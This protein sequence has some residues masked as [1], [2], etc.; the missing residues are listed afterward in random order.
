V[1]THWTTG[2]KDFYAL[3]QS[4]SFIVDDHAGTCLG[5]SEAGLIHYMVA[6]GR[7]E[8][9]RPPKGREGLSGPASGTSP[10]FERRR[11]SRTPIRP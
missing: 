1:R 3:N 10:A 7:A 8:H 2:G 5:C 4:C 6:A 11:R 9:D